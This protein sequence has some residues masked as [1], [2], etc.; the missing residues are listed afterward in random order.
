MKGVESLTMSLLWYFAK[1]KVVPTTE[2]TGIREKPT[3]E[4]NK[5]VA[6]VLE[7]QRLGQSTRKRRAT[8]HSEEARAKIG[9][10]ASI[11]G[12]ASARIPI[13]VMQIRMN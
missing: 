5:R 1:T 8:A 2:E 6:E 3:A 7:R 12:T 4:A 11:N 10:Y 9:K 13:P